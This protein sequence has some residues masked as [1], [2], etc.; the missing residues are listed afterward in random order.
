MGIFRG[1]DIVRD[2]L[3]LNLD[4]KSSRSYPGSGSTWYDLSGNGKHFTFGTGI[5][6]NAA[7]YFTNT[8]AGVFTGP[9]S[10]TFGFNSSNENYI[11]VYAQVISATG[12]VFFDFQA[13]AMDGGDNRAVF[14]HLYYSN[15]NTYYDIG[16]CC[17]VTQRISYANDTDLTAG[18]RHFSWRTRTNTTPNRQMFKNLVSQ[19]DSSTNSTGMSTWNLNTTAKI[20]NAWNGNLYVFRAYNRPLTD[21]E[22]LKNF[23]ATRKRFGL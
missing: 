23:N 16:G 14:S 12:N 21:D 6:W 10:N 15:G 17:G 3:I 22:M 13:T 11:E 4:A 2:G 20:A 9:A 8:G 5:S 1:P 19:V 18:V 7:G